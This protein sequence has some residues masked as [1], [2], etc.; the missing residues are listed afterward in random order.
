[1]FDMDGAYN[2]Q[3]E[4]NWAANRAEADA[5]GAIKQKRKCPQKGGT[6]DHDRYINEVLPVALQY[7]SKVFGN[8][9][10]FQQDGG[11]PHTH[12][13]TQQW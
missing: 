8:H 1:M 13:K 3:N 5:K 10:T 6:V 2:S 4:K 9:W 7:G 12:G 11:K